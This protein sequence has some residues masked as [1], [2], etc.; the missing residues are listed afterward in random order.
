MCEQYELVVATVNLMSLTTHRWRESTYT[1]AAGREIVGSI[2]LQPP[3]AIIC[4][5]GLDPSDVRPRPSKWP[6]E[7]IVSVVLVALAAALS[8]I[9]LH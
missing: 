9:V 6:P 7:L 1:S 8:A 3:E 2:D 5:T 4:W